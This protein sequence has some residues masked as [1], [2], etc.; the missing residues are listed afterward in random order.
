MQRIQKVAKFS[1]NNPFSKNL[2]T[3]QVEGKEYK[4]FS[5]PDLNDTR[6]SK[7]FYPIIF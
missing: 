7:L 1:T 5:L 4:Y 3:I 2:R 6:Y